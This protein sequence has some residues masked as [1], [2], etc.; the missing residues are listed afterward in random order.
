MTPHDHHHDA[1]LWVLAGVSTGTDRP[2]RAS[3]WAVSARASFSMDCVTARDWLRT[4]AV[5]AGAALADAVLVQPLSQAAPRRRPPTRPLALDGT[6]A[7]GLLA[8]LDDVAALFD[9]YLR[10]SR[11]YPEGVLAIG[12]EV[13]LMNPHLRQS[14]DTGDQGALLDHA[15]ELACSADAATAIATLPA[16]GGLVVHELQLIRPAGVAARVVVGRNTGRATAVPG[17]VAGAGV[18]C[19]D[20]CPGPDEERLALDAGAGA[21]AWLFV[22]IGPG[23]NLL[24]GDARA[25][26][27]GAFATCHPAGAAIVCGEPWISVAFE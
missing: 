13:V 4:I 6:S 19:R 9:A 24:A 18:R 3:R 12:G 10:H 1:S 22:G 14:L 2:A 5:T 15:A 8:L 26:P 23:R 20:R 25:A 16:P 21:Q 17:R 11:R 7:R 27:G